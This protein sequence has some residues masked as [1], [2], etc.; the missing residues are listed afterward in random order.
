MLAHVAV[1]A[2]QVEVGDIGV[3]TTISA[4]IKAHIKLHESDK[5]KLFNRTRTGKNLLI[6]AQGGKQWPSNP[7][8][9]THHLGI[10]IGLGNSNRA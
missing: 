5:N 4:L 1:D 7:H 2:A 3:I 6:I 9:F 10:L 8:G